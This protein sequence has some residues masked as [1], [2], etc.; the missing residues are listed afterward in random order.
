MWGLLISLALSFISYLIAPST[1]KTN[2]AQ[3]GTIGNDDI[4]KAE[5]GGN[6]PHFWGRRWIQRANI[7]Y[8]G[9]LNTIPIRKS[10][11]SKK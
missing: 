2:N 1:T 10:T 3:P 5:E 9:G 8:Y 4:N 11:A 7:I 6:I